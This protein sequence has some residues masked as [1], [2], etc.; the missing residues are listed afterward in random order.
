MPPA[1]SKKQVKGTT[2][3][4]PFD[5]PMVD[6]IRLSTDDIITISDETSSTIENLLP[7]DEP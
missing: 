4:R 7:E 6:V 2:N 5:E 1:S 3:M